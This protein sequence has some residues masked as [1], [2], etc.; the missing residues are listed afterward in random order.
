MTQRLRAHRKL[1]LIVVS[2][3]FSH[4]AVALALNVRAGRQSLQGASSNEKNEVHRQVVESPE[5][6]LQVAGNDDCPLRIVE[7]KVKDVPAALFTKLTGKTTNLV[8]VSSAPDVTLLNTS[9]HTITKFILIVR[10]PNSRKTRGVI[11]HDIALRPGETYTVQRELFVTPDSV[12]A[13]DATGQAQ[14]T[15]INPGIKSEKGWIDFAAR[16]DL[17]V[18]IGLINFED[19]SSWMVKEG[20]A[21]R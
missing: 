21:V 16:S 10:D 8:T 14:H 3:V 4:S 11:Q 18:T 9:D 13:T 7:A 19:G 20:G 6:P 15:L 17:F 2:L 5:Q 1:I 12:T